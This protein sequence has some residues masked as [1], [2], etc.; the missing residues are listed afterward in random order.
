M[1]PRPLKTFHTTVNLMIDAPVSPVTLLASALAAV[2]L[3]VCAPV[4][5]AQQRRPQGLPD[6]IQLQADIPYAGTD[7]AK[8]KLNLLLPQQ[9]ASTRPLPVIVYIHGGAWRAGDRRA[10]HRRV[11]SYVTSGQYA[12]VSVGYRLTDEAIWPAQIH[13][14]KAAIRWVRANAKQYNLNPDKIGVMGDSAGGQLVAMLGTSG[15]VKALEGTLGDHLTTSSKVQCVVDNFGPADLAAMKDYPSRMD[16]DRADSPEGKLVGGQVSANHQAAASAS[17]ISYVSKEDPPFL[18][19]HGTDDMLVPYNQS[20]RLAKAL[21]GVGAKCNFTTVTEGGHGGFRNPA[22]RQRER[23]FF[24]KHL[25]GV[26]RDVPDSDLPNEM[27]GK[28]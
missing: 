6:S 18:I 26:E 7:N 22:V 20:V 28:P 9:R 27:R 12:G 8:Q 3:F 5:S 11:A 17:P 1:I 16:H 14:C 4:S 23:Q 24:D 2:T 10:G 13:D 15:G 19:I 25:R 21:K